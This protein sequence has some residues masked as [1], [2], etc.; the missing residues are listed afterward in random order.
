M[1]VS[2]IY[3]TGSRL[4]SSN[5]TIVSVLA[6]YATAT[7]AS[8]MFHVGPQRERPVVSGPEELL[9]T[10]LRESEYASKTERACSKLR[11]AVL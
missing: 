3:C 5:V 9:E 8:G 10:C 7:L 11:P 2:V 4:N 6:I 1:D